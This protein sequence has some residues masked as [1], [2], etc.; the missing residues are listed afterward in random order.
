[1]P[2]VIAASWAVKENRFKELL[3]QAS[4]DREATKSREI[5]KQPSI[6][7]GIA[8]RSDA[9]VGAALFSS[10]CVMAV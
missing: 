6:V 9:R 4:D 3:W 5:N 10:S 1:M 2:N 8:A 7:A